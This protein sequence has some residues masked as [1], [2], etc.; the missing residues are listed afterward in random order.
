MKTFDLE[1]RAK[2]F[3]SVLVWEILLEDVTDRNKRVLDWIQAD[4]YRFKKLT[5]YAITDDVLTV[6]AGCQGIIGG[7]L[8]CEVFINGVAQPEKL[9]SKVEETEYAKA[10]YQIS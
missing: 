9:I 10:N 4:G 3:G 2:T 1:L 7:T 8:S 6:F 5:S